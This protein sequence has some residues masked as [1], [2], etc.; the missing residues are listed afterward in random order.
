MK[1]TIK[2]AKQDLPE[3]SLI[4]EKIVIIQDT[5]AQ[6]YKTASARVSFMQATRDNISHMLWM[7][8]EKEEQIQ[9]LE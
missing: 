3:Q 6:A 2:K 8:E 7:I 9:A 1:Q 4:V 5:F